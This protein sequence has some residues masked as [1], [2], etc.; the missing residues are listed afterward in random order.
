MYWT[1]KTPW[2]AA[3]SI[4][5][6]RIYNN[7]EINTDIS[8]SEIKEPLYLCT[9]NVNFSFDNNIYIQNDGVA[10]RSPLSSILANIS[11]VELERSVIP[12]LTNRLNNWRRYVD[13]TMLTP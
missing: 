12:G 5:L 4:T 11:M 13:D 7:R 1:I 9:K 8:L 10:M 6:N 3:I 2:Q